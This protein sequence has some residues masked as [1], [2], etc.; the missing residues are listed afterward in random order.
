MKY[1]VKI[2]LAILLL[3]FLGSCSSSRSYYGS[4]R[5]GKK[6]V[7]FETTRLGKN[8]LFF[9]RKYQKKLKKRMKKNRR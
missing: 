4:K 3:F 6:E 5:P 8:K 9:S 1:F 7:T 2:S